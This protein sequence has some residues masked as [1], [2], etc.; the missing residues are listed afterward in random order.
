MTDGQNITTICSKH[1]PEGYGEFVNGTA[2][3]CLQCNDTFSCK[4]SILKSARYINGSTSDHV[5]NESTKA[6]IALVIGC[7]TFVI[8]ICAIIFYLYRR[9]R[10]R[11]QRR[12]RHKE[13]V[14]FKICIYIYLLFYQ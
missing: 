7:L 8:V 1:C 4:N 10:K 3:V 6:T 14:R 9:T 11:K 2:N 12:A 5:S 13:N